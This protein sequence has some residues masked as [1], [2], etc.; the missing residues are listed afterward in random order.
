[1]SASSR[2]L[3]LQHLVRFAASAC[4]AS[5]PG[6]AQDQLVQ[7]VRELA[8]AGNFAAAE[9]RIA[10]A[11]KR[12]GESPASVLALSWLG[13]LAVQAKK[14]D[15]AARYASETRTKVEAM[16]GRRGLDEE[17][18]LPLAL[19]ASIEVQGQ[20]LAGT[21][22]R[23]E[24]VALLQKELQQW[25]KTSIRTRTQKNLHLLSLTGQ[26]MPKL[27]LTQWL[28]ASRPAKGPARPTLYFF[29]AHWCSDCKFQGPILAALRQ[30]Y[31]KLHI[32]A[33]T[34]PYG[35][36]ANGEDA[37]PAKELPYM[38]QVWTTLYASLADT[39]APVSQENFRR[40][41]CSTTPTLVL[42]DSAGIVRLYHPGKMTAEEL[43]PVL[44]QFAK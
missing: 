20:T 11:I 6:L 16:L 42:A 3:A 27:A 41:G 30:Q 8:A 15:A 23:S 35:Y 44:D 28:T 38:R 14:W 17:P 22:R 34:Q 2:R 12:D 26:A 10:D 7:Q 19:G 40:M 9:Q 25:F 1:M 39:P 5:L 37:P 4:L 21:G 13:R 33:P 36:V 43:R 31:P 18:Q 24:A 32:I 29:W